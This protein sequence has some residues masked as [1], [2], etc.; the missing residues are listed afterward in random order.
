MNDLKTR[1]RTDVIER[2][3]RTD[4]VT[5]VLM[6]FMLGLH[7]TVI[8]LQIAHSLSFV[9]A[10]AICCFIMNMSFTFWHECSHENLSSNR[11]LNIVTGI[12]ASFFSFFPGYFARRREHLVHH[13][14]EGIPGKD[15]VYYRIQN[16]NFYKFLWTAVVVN[17]LEK[18]PNE[19]PDSFMEIS[20]L[21][22]FIDRLTVG[23]VWCVIGVLVYAGFW[24]VAFATIL[25]PRVF[26]F[27]YHGYVIC[28]FPHFIHGCGYQKFRVFPRG[29]FFQAITMNQNLHG[30]HHFIPRVRWYNYKSVYQKYR[31]E[32]SENN[33]ETRP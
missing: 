1:I 2:Q 23:S 4:Y 14:Y 3:S 10:C 29:F 20:P 16:T 33:I 18:K 28:F 7:V 22:K 13:R 19:V 17:Y 12:I 25:I 24:Q 31:G 21:Q 11:R 9:L 26:I 32:F 5:L 30:I 15:P 6:A 8:Y 27:I